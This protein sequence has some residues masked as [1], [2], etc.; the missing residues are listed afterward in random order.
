MALFHTH[1]FSE[2][3]GMQSEAIVV[4]PQPAGE[5]QIGVPPSRK[6]RKHW[7][8]LWLLHGLSDD[9]TAW[10]RR[11]SIERYAEAAGI[12]VVMP[13]VHRSFYSNM[14]YGGAYSDFLHEELPRLMRGFFPL[15][16]AKCDNAVAGLSMGGYGAFKW[17]LSSPETFQAAASLSGVMDISARYQQLRTQEPDSLRRG[18][19]DLV[20]GNEDPENGLGDLFALTQSLGDRAPPLLQLCGTEDFLYPENLRFRDH[21][22]QYGVP[23][24]YR[25][26]PGEHEW[27]FWDREIQTVLSWLPT[28]GFAPDA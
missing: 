27:G 12:A 18:T 6:V 14:L 17:A 13:N 7:P 5:R 4:L 19:L 2:T 9:H 11:T 8:C 16:P 24:D 25:E 3:L 28:Q 1:F 10:T 26:G 20:F 22:R 15:S 21:A 23:L